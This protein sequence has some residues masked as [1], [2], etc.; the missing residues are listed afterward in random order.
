MQSIDN[1]A[2]QVLA[3]D[4]Q[5]TPLGSCRCTPLPQDLDDLPSSNEPFIRPQ[6]ESSAKE[7]FNGA[8]GGRFWWLAVS[9]KCRGRGLAG[10]L[11]KFCEEY[12]ARAVQGQTKPYMRIR[13]NFKAHLMYPRFGY[14]IDSEPFLIA[15]QKLIWMKKVLGN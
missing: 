5:G 12:T 1:N 13:A 14:A 3:I 11:I 9:P 7:L 2:L 15:D 4:E 10:Q 6:S 8:E